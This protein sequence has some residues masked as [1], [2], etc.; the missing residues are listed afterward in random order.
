MFHLYKKI[1]L[2]FGLLL[3]AISCKNKSNDTII[4]ENYLKNKFKKEI[5]IKPRTYILLSEN[6]CKM[7]ASTILNTS[8]SIKDSNIIFIFPVKY[9]TYFENKNNNNI[10]IDKTN[11]I[12]KLKF[13]KGSVCKIMTSDKKVDT[14][15]YYELED[16][17]SAIN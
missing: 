6:S 14:I 8:L 11:A 12:N 10:L 17:E 16:I 5:E 3:S 2:I 7:C 13:N 1:I 4:F 15:I 9:S